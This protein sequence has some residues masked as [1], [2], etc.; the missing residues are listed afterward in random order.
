[1]SRTKTKKY[2]HLTILAA[3]RTGLLN[4]IEMSSVSQ[5]TKFGTHP[6]IDYELLARYG[7]GLIVL[8][9]SIA[10]PVAGRLSRITGKD[11]EAGA[12]KSARAEGNRAALMAAVGADNVCVELGGHGQAAQQEVLARLYASAADSEL[13]VV[14]ADDSHYVA[15]DE[16]VVHE[17]HKAL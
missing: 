7:E 3:T 14:V 2:E 1:Q 12:G 17:G 4:L 8:T 16:Q 5:E 11:P 13:P 15:D 10:G 9:G 6:L